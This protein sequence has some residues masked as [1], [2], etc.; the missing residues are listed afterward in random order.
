MYLMDKKS[1]PLKKVSVNVRAPFSAIYT[2]L[3][4]NPQHKI[5]DLE[6]LDL[7]PVV[8]EALKAKVYVMYA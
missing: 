5:K 3:R 2:Y 6:T 7:D 4:S 8:K 1:V